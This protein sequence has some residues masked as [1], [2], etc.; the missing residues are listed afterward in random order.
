[1]TYEDAS[2]KAIKLGWVHTTPSRGCYGWRGP[3]GELSPSFVQWEGARNW[4]LKRMEHETGEQ[5]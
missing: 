1:M 5:D 2:T 3:D 4:L